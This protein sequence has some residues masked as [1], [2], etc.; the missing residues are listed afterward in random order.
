[1][2]LER[3]LELKN[4]LD[5]LYRLLQGL[6]TRKDNLEKEASGT[7]EA[8][9]RLDYAVSNA[10]KW[11]QNLEHLRLRPEF[12]EDII[13]PVERK[14]DLSGIADTVLKEVS[15][16]ESDIERTNGQIWAAD[17][18]KKQLEMEAP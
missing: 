17:Q 16:I 4:L 3:V 13:R 6:I 8:Q 9:E 2:I 7:E 12:L 1:M 14:P 18:E 15:K 10:R 5:R 11:V